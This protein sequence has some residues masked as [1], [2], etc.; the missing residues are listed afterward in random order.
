MCFESTPPAAVASDAAVPAAQAPQKAPKAAGEGGQREE[1]D[2][3][4]GGRACF[5]HV[6]RRLH[7]V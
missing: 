5:E 7:F 6:K 2:R 3:P 1:D 4:E